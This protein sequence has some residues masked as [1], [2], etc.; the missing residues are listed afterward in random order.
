MGWQVY[1]L[2]N[3]AL[4]L[5][6]IG[7]V[8]AVPAIALALFAGHFVD[9]TDPLKVYK[10]VLRLNL[11][12]AATLWAV[13]GSAFG[14]PLH[15]RVLGLYAASF[16]SGVGLGFALP[17]RDGL[18]PRLVA[19]EEL[20]ETSAWTVSAYHLAAVAGPALGGA[21]FGW[22]GARVPHGLDLALFATAL[23]ALGP[24][25]LAPRARQPRR[26]GLFDAVTS[27]LRYVFSHRVLLPAI[28]LDM[29]AV[30]FGGVTAL[31][32]VFAKD[33]LNVGPLG[34][35]LLRAA[36][37]AGALL[38][39]GW[40]IRRPVRR[41]AGVVLL[42]VVAGFGATILGFALSRSF[43]LSAA[44]LAL[45]GAFDSVSMVI[46]VVIVQMHSPDDMRGRISAVNSV[47]ISV[48]NELGAF[49]SGLAAHL[50]GVVPSVL[51]GG[52]V[53]MVTVAAVTL[54]ARDMRRMHL[55]T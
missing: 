43:A 20:H 50:L 11:V 6:L 39:S 2:T 19:R 55:D 9:R 7:L 44:L 28:T 45:G 23:A 53:T 5:G 18:V 16:V 10:N 15:A 51:A 41:N 17:A 47:F 31:L 46:R 35:D 30:L 3:S 24:V 48:S 21:L 37:A 4:A 13:S 38:A 36:P 33:I 25:K 34:L 32:P 52:L 29:F 8:Q 27:G 26:E 12:A 42:W 1:E 22:L 54:S 49:E 14:L 40:L